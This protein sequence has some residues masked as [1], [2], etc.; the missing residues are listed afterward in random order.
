VLAWVSEDV[1]EVD[2]G[3]CGMAGSFGYGHHDLSMAI[4]E[5]RLYEGDR[6]LFTRNRRALGVEN[7]NLG[8]V[9]KIERS[10]LTV[11]LDKG[12]AV[13]LDLADYDFVQL[14]YACTAHKGQGVTIDRNAY[15]LA[16]GAMQDLHLSYVQASRAKEQTRFY[17]DRGEAGEDLAQLA[18]AMSRD[19]EKQL[20]HDQVDEQLL[21][22]RLGQRLQQEQG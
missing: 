7:G 13:Q 4:G 11:Q 9:D 21:G 8:T 6:V 22:R 18:E 14:G 10:V 5:Q 1:R 3:C 20:A 15:V 17:V 19:R 12:R 16:G 2:S